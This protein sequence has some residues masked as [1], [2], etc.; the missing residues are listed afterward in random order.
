MEL[1]CVLLIPLVLMVFWQP[2]IYRFFVAFVFVLFILISEF[3]FYEVSGELYY[4]IDA[5][6]YLATM[7]IIV[8]IKHTNISLLLVTLGFIAILLNFISWISFEIYLPPSF[9][10]NMFSALNIVALFIL[11]IPRKRNDIIRSAPVYF[12]ST[13]FCIHNIFNLRYHFKGSRKT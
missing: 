4:L 2:D 6:L 1:Y 12:S 9:N 11:A 13:F 5:L 3:L 10:D 7:K 8:N